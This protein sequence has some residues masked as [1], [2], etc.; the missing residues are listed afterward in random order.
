[1]KELELESQVNNLDTLEIGDRLAHYMAKQ[2]IADYQTARYKLIPNEQAIGTTL[3]AMF[4]CEQKAI[5]ALFP[6]Y[7]SKSEDK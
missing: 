3:R 4:D 2:K 5:S 7:P 1:M 6:D